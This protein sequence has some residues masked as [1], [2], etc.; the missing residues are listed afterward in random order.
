MERR[1]LKQLYQSK[2]TGTQT[3][4]DTDVDVIRLRHEGTKILPAGVNRKSLKFAGIT[5]GD[6]DEV[7]AALVNAV[8]G[9]RSKLN[10]RMLP[11]LNS[12]LVKLQHKFCILQW[13]AGRRSLCGHLARGQSKEQTRRAFEEGDILF[14]ATYEKLLQQPAG[15]FH[16]GRPGRQW[17]QPGT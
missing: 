12:T 7:S 16:P 6:P 15:T 13:A 3:S 9:S 10:T 14:R 1:I 2:R 17:H 4:N 11:F 5:L 8:A